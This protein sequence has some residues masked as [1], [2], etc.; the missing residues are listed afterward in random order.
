MDRAEVGRRWA[1]MSHLGQAYGRLWEGSRAATEDDLARF[2]AERLLVEKARDE[3]L[4]AF[5]EYQDNP[6]PRGEATP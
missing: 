2:G 1:A 4:A 6:P 5:P 3:F